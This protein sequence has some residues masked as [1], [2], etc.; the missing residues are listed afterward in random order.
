MRAQAGNDVA[1]L[2][3]QFH[4][5]IRSTDG[6]PYVVQVWGEPD[7]GWHGWLVFIAVDGSMLRTARLTSRRS[8][9]LLHRWATRLR[10]RALADALTQ[11]IPPSAKLP[12]A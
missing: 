4:D 2:I 3:H 12:A 7:Q 9:D 10:A 5:P 8:R 1:E 11:G 6:V